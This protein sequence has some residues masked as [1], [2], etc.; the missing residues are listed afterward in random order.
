MP[1]LKE[2]FDMVTNQTEPDLDS[3]KQQ[4]ERQRRTARNRK[5]GVFALAAA[6]AVVAFVMILRADDGSRSTTVGTDVMSSPER[7]ASSFVGAYGSFDADKAIG[8]LA[9]D[10][11]ISGLLLG[12]THVEG[13]ESELRL[14]LAM[15]D[16]AGFIQLLGPCEVAQTAGSA[17][18]V[19]C[20]FDF[21][22]AG[23]DY[24]GQGSAPVTGA[25]YDL[26]VDGDEITGASVDWGRDLASVW[27]EF[28]DWVSRE[29]PGDAVSMFT[30]DSHAT[31]RMSEE[32]IPLWRRNLYRY[33]ETSPFC[34]A[35]PHCAG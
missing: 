24:G 11:D 1:E 6:I 7:I 15:L 35:A 30:D 2:V 31:I 19:Q 13:V 4:D 25:F 28:A 32:S 23:S 16:A 26:S 9:D 21:H 5:L 29:H 20:P 14:N 3:W 8:Y 34:L 33:V 10:A 17:T 22:I 18:T 27:K 12:P